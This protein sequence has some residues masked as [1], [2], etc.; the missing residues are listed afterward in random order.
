MSIVYN[1]TLGVLNKAMPQLMVVLVGAPAITFLA[2]V[3]LAATAPALL[4][5]WRTAFAAAL[6][7]P[8][9]GLR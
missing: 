3:V 6:L 9:D 5:A 2:L 7:D 8:A 1:V 4:E